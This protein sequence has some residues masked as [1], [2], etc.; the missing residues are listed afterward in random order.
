MGLA[1]YVIPSG[2]MILFLAL[3]ESFH[4]FGIGLRNIGEC[5]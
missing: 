4:P 3:L 5:S 1:S 2:F